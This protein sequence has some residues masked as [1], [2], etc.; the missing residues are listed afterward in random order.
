SQEKEHDWGYLPRHFFCLKSTYDSINDL[1]L[2][3]DKCHQRKIR[4]FLDCVFN[5]SACSY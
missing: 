1:K 2:L 3:V 5:H 4:V